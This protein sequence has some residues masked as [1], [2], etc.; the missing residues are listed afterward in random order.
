[1]DKGQL[2][3]RV[4]ASG[5]DRLALAKILDRAAQAL[6]RNV[7]AATDFLSPQ[8]QMQALDLLRLAGVS[9]SSYVLTGGYEGAE[10]RLF[11]FLPDWLEPESA[12]DYSPVRVLRAAFR[13]AD[14][15]GH[16]DF[17]GSL[18]GIGIVREKIGDILVGPESADLLVLESVE[19]FLLQSW[20][21]A[22]RAR[23]TVSS[24]LPDCLHI[25]AAER[26]EIRDT[27][28]SL[29]LDAVTAA[30]FRMARGKAAD[31]IAAGRVQLNWR[32]C[33]KPDRLLQEGDVVSARGYGKFKLAEIGKL[34]KK[35][36]TAIKL[37]KYV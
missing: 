3:D 31:L 1:M 32:E 10:R 35:G 18:M 34:T 7:P 16:R 22:G 21:S 29:R 30:G 20:T 33:T 6:Q 11:L 5:E 25:P 9:P 2:L 24:V 13:E 15:P 23:L 14:A 28:S 37:M 8:Q 27:V 4:G 36:R 17:L 12:F 26:E 19:A